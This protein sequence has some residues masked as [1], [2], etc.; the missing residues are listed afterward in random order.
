MSNCRFTALVK[1]DNTFKTM[2]THCSSKQGMTTTAHSTEVATKMVRTIEEKY[3]MVVKRRWGK[4]KF[5][6]LMKNNDAQI[7]KMLATLKDHANFA[8]RPA[9]KICGRMVR[10]LTRRRRAPNKN[11][12]AQIPR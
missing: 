5:C 10:Q 7:K 12:M 11:M 2:H 1:N 6:Q 4:N 9:K 3:T 8:A